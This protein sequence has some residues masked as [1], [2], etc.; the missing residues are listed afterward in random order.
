MELANIVLLF[1]GCAVASLMATRALLPVLKRRAILD[2]PNQRSSHD[3][4]TPKGGGIAVIAVVLVAWVMIGLRFDAGAAITW[5]LPACA[6]GLAVLS[7]ADDL[8]ELSPALR[9]ASHAAAV[10]T[11]LYFGPE[12]GPFFMGILPPPV[13]T[14]AAGLLWVWFINLFNFMDGIDGITGIEAASIGLGAMLLSGGTI[15]LFGIVIGGAAAGFLKLNWHPA[16][17]FLGDVGSV[18]MGFLLGWLLLTLAADGNWAAAL[19]LPAYYLADATTTLVRRGLR[20]EKVWRA[21][22]EHFYQQ[23]VRRG[24]S[25]SAVSR[26]VLSMNSVL[27]VLAVL[28][29]RGWQGPALIAAAALTALFLRWLASNKP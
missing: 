14:L 12:H 9:L 29:V 4:A 7:W 10:T 17:V 6:L 23:A 24:L 15:G 5:L 3:T 21:H 22:R 26:A 18:P 1:A 8:G 20:G 16:R 25:H 2:H 11:I 19:I 27:I 28:S 13:D